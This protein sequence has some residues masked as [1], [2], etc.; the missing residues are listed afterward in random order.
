MRPIDRFIEA[1][2]QTQY[3]AFGLEFIRQNKQ[4]FIDNAEG[5][6]DSGRETMRGLSPRRKFELEDITFEKKLDVKEIYKKLIHAY[7][8]STIIDMKIIADEYVCSS[9]H[10]SGVSKKDSYDIMEKSTPF[11]LLQIYKGGKPHHISKLLFNVRN[12]IV[13]PDKTDNNSIFKDKNIFEILAQP[14]L[15]ASGNDA[16]FL[17]FGTKQENKSFIEENWMNTWNCSNT[18]FGDLLVHEYRNTIVMLDYIL[19]TKTSQKECIENNY[20]VPLTLSI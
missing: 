15:I 13:H 10:F 12:A 20:W 4:R 6:Y 7:I 17:L 1:A 11:S 9:P 16:R 14:V 3:L 5:K 18:I 19:D 8:R 2:E